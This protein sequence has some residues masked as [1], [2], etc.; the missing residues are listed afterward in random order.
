MVQKIMGHD[1]TLDVYLG[2][3]V[4]MIEITLGL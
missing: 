3:T 2:S 1:Y 4:L